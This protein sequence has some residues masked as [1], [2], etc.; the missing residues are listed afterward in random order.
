MLE[1]LASIIFALMQAM[2]LVC[3]AR[4]DC[5]LASRRYSAVEPSKAMT[6]MAGTITL[7][8]ATLTSSSAADYASITANLNS[9]ICS[10]CAHS[11]WT[12]DPQCTFIG[13]CP[14][15][16]CTSDKHV[17]LTVPATNA[18][19]DA[20]P[21][22]ASYLLRVTACGDNVCD[23]YYNCD[24]KSQTRWRLHRFPALE[25]LTRRLLRPSLIIN[26]LS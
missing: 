25:V 8:V 11:A 5:R 7:K 3:V 12:A 19:C 2:M 22:I 18:S 14:N 16:T 13:I 1:M 9:V 20:T 26:F 23:A 24:C 6:S 10:C 17:E 21:T 15:I 4:K